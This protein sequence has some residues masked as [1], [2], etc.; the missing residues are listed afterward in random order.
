MELQQLVVEDQALPAEWRRGFW[1][2][3]RKNWDTSPEPQGIHKDTGLSRRAAAQKDLI[4]DVVARRHVFMPDMEEELAKRTSRLNRRRARGKVKQKVFQRK[5]E[6]ALGD[7]SSSS[8]SSSDSIATV[9][10]A[11]LVLSPAKINQLSRD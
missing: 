7:A 2:T 5:K 3:G 4:P 6:K 8:N 9:A 1:D 11:I 10:P